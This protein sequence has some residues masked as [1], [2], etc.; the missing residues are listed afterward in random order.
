MG[1]IFRARDRHTGEPVAV[2]VLRAGTVPHI[3]RF[4]Q[5]ARALSE[6]SHPRIVRYMTH[7]VA[8]PDCPYLAMEWLEGE[9]LST[10]LAR[11]R[12]T[13][14]E[15]V[16]LAS[17]VA[18]ALCVAHGRRIVHRDLKPGNIF[19]VDRRVDQVKVLDFGVARLDAASKITPTGAV[20]GTPGYMAPEQAQ[21]VRTVDARADVFSLGCVLF[22]C[23]TGSPAFS[24][25]HL[26]SLLAKVLYAEPPPLR[27]LVPGAKPAL[28]ELLSRMLAKRPE[29]RPRDGAAVLSALRALKLQ[30]SAVDPAR[31]PIALTT[32]ER[33]T[34][35]VVLLA[36][37]RAEG[38][39]ADETL[40]PAESDALEALRR[41]AAVR[42]WRLERLRDGSVTAWMGGAGLATDQAAQAARCALWLRGRTGGRTTA[43]ATGRS[44]AA[45]SRATGEAIERAAQL[46]HAR[47]TEEGEGGVR[48]DE[49]TARLLDGRFDV[50]ESG[51]GLALYGERVIAE[52]ARP[53]LG[54][55]TPCVGRRRELA[56][57]EQM[58][59]GCVEEQQARAALLV[60]TAGIGKSRLAHEL[61]AQLRRRGEP[62]ACWIG[63]GDAL[64]AG[65]A[66]GL[67]GQALRG[68]CGIRGDEPLPERRGKLSSRVALRV[69]ASERQRVAEILGEIVGAPFPE[70]KSDL[71][72]AA[73]R[74]AQIMSDQ[75]H[76]A[77]TE[78][79]RAECSAQPVLLLLEDWHWGD[80]ATGRF[81]D[82][83]LRD[84]DQS[85]WLVLALSRPEASERFPKLWHDRRLHVIHLA[86]LGRKPSERLVRQVLGDGVDAET[87]KR[88]VAQADGNAFYLEELIR[89]AAE[90]G[91]EGLP[92]TVVAMVQ[93]RL[94]ALDDEDRRVLRAASI[95][96]EASWPGG[97]AAL[98]GGADR[99]AHVER[100]MLGLVE[101][102][103]LVRRPESRFSAEVELAF[104]HTL[105]REGAYAMLTD[106]D[107]ALGHGVAGEWLERAGE[108]DPKLLATHFDR[109]GVGARAAAYYL[110]ASELALDT[111]DCETAIELSERGISL[112]REP[113]LLAG[114]KA[115]MGE[116][117]FRTGDF[118]GA[119]R[120]AAEALRLARPGSRIEGRAIHSGIYTALYLRRTELLVEPMERLLR[121]DPE[122]DAIGL[123]AA[124][125]FSV[126][127]LLVWQARR[128]TMD[129]YRQR[130]EQ[131]SRGVVADPSALAWMELARAMWA[132]HV[133]RDPW[134]LLQHA[135]R[136]SAHHERSGVGGVFPLS[137]FCIATGYALLGLFDRAEEELARTLAMAPSTGHE[138][139]SAGLT[140]TMMLVDQRRTAEA[141]ALAAWVVKEAELRGEQLMRLNGWLYGIEARLHEGAVEAAESLA[142]QIRD[143]MSTE[144]YLGMAYLVELAGIRL[145]QGHAE[146]AADIADRA[147][148]QA[149]CFGM[150][151]FCRHATLLLIR[152]EARC[153]LGDRDAAGEAIRD[154]AEDLQRRAA[155]IP[156]PVARQSFL[157]NLPDHRRTRELAR[158]WL[159]EDVG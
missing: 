55:P 145:A 108:R 40:D 17:G 93:S 120:A 138:G 36:A 119:F 39:G 126:I 132:I 48:V 157:E 97:V 75:M 85:P 105:L 7:G 99:A 89:R 90:P 104:R 142:L 101:R 46:L 83:A 50:R 33:R 41:G 92:E 68:A 60:G 115:A 131:V 123:L 133:E 84:L 139:L 56:E 4:V 79:L 6:L 121:T 52:G 25:E 59:A 29:D 51:A 22:E 44:G 74:N 76:R 107:R 111:G 12:L 127:V 65:A 30:V 69:A 71:L 5:E 49:T 64:R 9:D 140:R 134:G 47:V 114:L 72:R 21:N 122:P 135:R 118:Q 73:R 67:L 110:R 8:E 146:E 86:P 117:R 63:R 70:E 20:V 116:A 1:Q 150:G 11:A 130:L 158:T 2:K 137:Q 98:L 88:I 31:A 91:G 113:E 42:G 87:V 28:E 77:W 18:E 43:V 54:K 156:D 102:E 136:A 82:S 3:A 34:V 154:A 14:D 10:R 129:L 57:L 141:S 148:A 159:L 96:G 144:P 125:F 13:I 143:A 78:F 37:H 80:G 128:D 112:G 35:S 45:G 27:E 66:L 19:L 38:G 152:A 15:G 62:L 32:D 26:V 94:A 149:R 24:G 151:F 124:A 53:L 23:L 106:E 100:R 147:F 153:T 16:E 155:R 81:I 61:L 58:F 103:V 95:F 109:G